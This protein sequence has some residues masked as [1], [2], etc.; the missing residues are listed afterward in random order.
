M[1][2]T[3]PARLQHLGTRVTD[4]LRW[5]LCEMLEAGLLA[6]LVERMEGGVPAL[7]PVVVPGLGGD[8]HLVHGVGLGGVQVLN[9]P[10]ASNPYTEHFK[11]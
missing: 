3:L 11:I 10:P 1:L 2:Q 5:E 4:P 9:V 7:H 8:L 6:L